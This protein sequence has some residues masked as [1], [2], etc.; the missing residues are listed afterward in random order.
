[1]M[2]NLKKTEIGSGTV[3]TIVCLVTLLTAM[4]AVARTSSPSAATRTSCFVGKTVN[5]DKQ[6]AGC[7][8]V[9]AANGAS[10]RDRAGAYLI[11]GADYLTRNDIDNAI[12]DFNELIRIDPR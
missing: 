2:T 4:P 9:I 1:M 7:T 3:R 11:R 6:I 5:T 10:T 8:A 12:A